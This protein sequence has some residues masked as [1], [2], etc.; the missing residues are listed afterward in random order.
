VNRRKALSIAGTTTAMFVGG[1]LAVAANLG[2]LGF[3]RA[4]APS[5]SGLEPNR[6]V[7][8]Q[9][10]DATPRVVTQYEDVVVPTPTTSVRPAPT[11]ASTRPDVRQTSDD[12]AAV[13]TTPSRSGEREDDAFEASS[14][15]SEPLEPIVG[16]RDDD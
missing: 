8:T 12:G 13:N 14:S 11:T 15:T 6:S 7:V 2:L 10:V 4:E 16:N 5:L 1:T 3:A 9:P